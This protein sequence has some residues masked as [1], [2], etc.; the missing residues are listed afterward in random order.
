MYLKAISQQNPGSRRTQ[1]QLR[2]R[3]LGTVYALTVTAAWLIQDPL[4]AVGNGYCQ[5]TEG[6][7]HFACLRHNVGPK[8]SCSHK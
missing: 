1:E 6:G 3:E 5:Q 7:F 8:S 4:L 2:A